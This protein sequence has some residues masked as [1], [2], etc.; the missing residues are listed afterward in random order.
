MADERSLVGTAT[1]LPGEAPAH[2]ILKPPLPLLPPLADYFPLPLS[3][4]MDAS[5]AG[6]D[7]TSR[8]EMR[9]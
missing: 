5:R 8:F 1:A 2:R 4:S 3:I 6:V 7:A 9:H